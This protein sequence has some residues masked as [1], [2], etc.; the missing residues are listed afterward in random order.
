MYS[1][2]PPTVP[3]QRY[4][5]L[6]LPK[7]EKYLFKAFR[8]VPP[9]ERAE[10][11]QQASCLILL[12]LKRCWE[13]GKPYL[14]HWRLYAYDAV[15]N[16]RRGRDGF[17]RSPGKQRDTLDRPHAGDPG[18]QTGT[19]TVPPVAE[20]TARVAEFVEGL[21]ERLRQVYRY[22][23]LGCTTA[24]VSQ[25]LKI[26]TRSVERFRAQLRTRATERFSA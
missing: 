6:R 9:E 1:T 16:V 7:I 17:L 25:A 5:E 13:S 4:L 3:W 12:S 18:L 26:S 21:P 22:L 10:K 8:Y 14:S 11:I 20:E 15:R 19:P 2:A 23:D 24:E